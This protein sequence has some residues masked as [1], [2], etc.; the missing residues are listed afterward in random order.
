MDG[1]RAKESPHGH[2]CLQTLFDAAADDKQNYVAGYNAGVA[3]AA[4]LDELGGLR[5]N[6]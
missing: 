5:E 4:F 1:Y 3:V 2:Q 6:A